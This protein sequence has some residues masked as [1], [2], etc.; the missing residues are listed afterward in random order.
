MG[1]IRSECTQRKYGKKKKKKLAILKHL[2]QF[3]FSL[4]GSLCKVFDLPIGL[5][6]NDFRANFVSPV[7]LLPIH[8]PRHEHATSAV[9]QSKSRMVKRN[10]M[11][12]TTL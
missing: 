4:I 1:T 9:S 2:S 7:A 11:S 10:R 8:P 12:R 3:P 6:G 5:I